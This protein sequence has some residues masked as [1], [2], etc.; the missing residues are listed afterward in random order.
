MSISKPRHDNNIHQAFCIDSGF[1]DHK[2][3]W[4]PQEWNKRPKKKSVQIL[5]VV[6][7]SESVECH[8]IE[9]V[10]FFGCLRPAFSFLSFFILDIFSVIS[11]AFCSREKWA[12]SIA[13]KMRVFIKS[14]WIVFIGERHTH[15]SPRCAYVAGVSGS[16][17]RVALWGISEAPC[18]HPPPYLAFFVGG[19][20]WKAWGGGG[21]H[22]ADVEVLLYGHR[23]R[24]L[25]RDGSPG[26]PPQL[27]HRSE[28][29][30]FRITTY[31]DSNN[32]IF[33]KCQPL[34]EVGV[35]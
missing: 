23:N 22:C 18:H 17:C 4:R 16:L 25:I 1:D 14:E 2:P 15:R 19:V 7:S 28:A 35:L 31:N 10:L 6:S 9:R 34:T 27:S 3:F 5:K 13:C 33:T 20:R 32:E 12:S 30:Y 29:L 8:P 24:R 21:G 26:R 11:V